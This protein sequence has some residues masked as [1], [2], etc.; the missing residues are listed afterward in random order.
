MKTHW[1]PE[2][3]QR[4]IELYA[5]TQ[6]SEI[7]SALGIP[8]KSVEGKAYFLRLKKDKAF[9]KTLPRPKVNAGA[10]KPGHTS[11]NKGL[12]G[13]CVGG[14]ETQF[15]KGDLPHNTRPMGSLRIS[16]RLNK[17]KEKP[18]L[19]IKVGHKKWI[20]YARYVFAQYYGEIPKG[21]II[22]HING[23]VFDNRLENL[24]CISRY[25]NRLKNSPTTLLP[26]NY[27]V[28]TLL[29]CTIQGEERQKLKDAFKAT[30]NL[31]KLKRNLIQ[32][33]RACQTK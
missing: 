15:K 14:E 33:K 32:L 8:I 5:G 24:E 23:K 30:P 3:E 29:N 19:E 10:F 21:M 12:K 20:P 25:A 1:T 26:D 18:C 7:A 27:V 2:L 6:N 4:L 9:W 17:P 11:W 16:F 28:A 13:V 31:I 22:R